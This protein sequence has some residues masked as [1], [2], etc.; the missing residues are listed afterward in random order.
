MF[1][2]F[3]FMIMSQA[4]ECIHSKIMMEVTREWERTKVANIIEKLI[5][6]EEGISNHN[7]AV[8]ERTGGVGEI[9]S[10]IT[11]TR[12]FRF[13]NTRKLNDNRKPSKPNN[14]QHGLNT[15]GHKKWCRKN[16]QRNWGNVLMS[17]FQKTKIQ[18]YIKWA[19]KTYNKS[20]F[21]WNL[22]F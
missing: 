6:V 16:T 5:K 9:P 12:C 7:I 1:W 20:W 13:G 22:V 8:C 17:Q 15:R 4:C 2:H 11:F 10:G 3:Y 19:L 14:S 18:R 21:I